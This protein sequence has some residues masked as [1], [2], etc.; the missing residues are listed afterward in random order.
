MFSFLELEINVFVDSPDHG[1]VFKYLF[2]KHEELETISIRVASERCAEG[3]KDIVLTIF[4][5]LNLRSITIHSIHTEV[6]FNC[7]PSTFPNLERLVLYGWKS[8]SAQGLVEI[9]NRSRNIRVLDLSISNITG[10]EL[11]EGVNSLP[12][13]EVLKLR[14]C[15]NLTDGELKKILRLSGN[16]LRVLDVSWTKITEQGFMEGVSLP[17]LEELN[18]DACELT[19]SGLLEILSISSGTRLKTV[20]TFYINTSSAVE[21]TLLTQYPSVQ[22]K[23]G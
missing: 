23:F 1:S 9:L 4:S 6:I 8:L 15:K 7:L 10:V 3:E 13:L 17:M 2:K 18:L 14:Y 5:N 19:D 12:N 21:S 22:F 11:E 20:T 16:K